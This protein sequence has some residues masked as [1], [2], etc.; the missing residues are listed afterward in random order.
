LLYFLSFL[1]ICK[2]YRQDLFLAVSR[3]V[4]SS[5]SVFRSEI[6]SCNVLNILRGNSRQFIKVG[7]KP[8]VGVKHLRKTHPERLVGN[9]FGAVCEQGACLL[10]SPV[11]FFLGWQIFL[12]VG[13]F[14][15]NC[16]DNFV[17]CMLGVIDCRDGVKK[18]GEIPT[19][20]PARMIR[21]SPGV[22]GKSSGPRKSMYP[23]RRENFS[24][25]LRRFTRSLKVDGLW[26][27]SSSECRMAASS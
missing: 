5:H 9:A 1:Y 17:T 18:R 26:W 10:D 8:V 3:S 21:K 24:S 15:V 12:D 20:S 23:F 4:N 14:P 6:F 13:N 19:I 22:P 7:S 11:Q 27:N 16:S 25:S 2:W